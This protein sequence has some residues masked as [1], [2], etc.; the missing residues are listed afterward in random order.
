M[1]ISQDKGQ[2]TLFRHES[3]QLWESEVRGLILSKKKDFITMSKAGLNILALGAIDKRQV[4]D[5]EKNERMVHSLESVNY[6]KVAPEN[7]VLFECSDEDRVVSIQQEFQ[8]SNANSG[9]ETNY[10]NIYS[11]KIHEITLRELLLFQSLFVCKTQ[12]DIV[13]LVEDQPNPMVF[14]KSFLEFD[15][16][17]MVSILSFDSRSMSHLLDDKH[18]DFF[19]DEFPIFYRNKIQKSGGKYFYRS[20]IDRSLRCN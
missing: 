9:A 13:Q 1:D 4:I 11:I 8:K 16:A 6:L 10:E 12:S 14:Y 2:T 15:G 20:A 17:N 7:F 3:F 19:S 5:A 18:A